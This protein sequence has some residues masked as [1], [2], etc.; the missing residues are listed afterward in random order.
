MRAILAAARTV[1]VVTFAATAT[2]RKYLRV[3]T[4]ARVRNAR[5]FTAVGVLIVGH[6]LSPAKIV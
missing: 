1:A 4:A 3:R 2:Q 6:T 5:A